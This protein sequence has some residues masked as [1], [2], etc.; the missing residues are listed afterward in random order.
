MVA[1]EVVSSF[2]FFR[3][4]ICMYNN[5]CPGLTSNGDIVPYLRELLLTGT[6]FSE[7]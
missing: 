5:R 6:H 3:Y 7:I 2:I 4:V 1:V